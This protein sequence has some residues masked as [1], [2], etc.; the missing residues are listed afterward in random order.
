MHHLSMLPHPSHLLKHLRFPS[1][2]L[3]VLRATP[4][5]LMEI[6]AWSLHWPIQKLHSFSIAFGDK[7]KVLSM[8][9]KILHN[10][11]LFCLSCIFPTSV[12]KLQPASTPYPIKQYKWNTCHHS[13]APK[14]GLTSVLHIGTLAGHCRPP[15]ADLQEPCLRKDQMA[16][17]KKCWDWCQSQELWH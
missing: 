11:I 2:L 6:L 16:L 3:C 4:S 9:Q 14:G 7:A 1:F 13:K 8:V 10:S 15:G 5:Y 12:L 17:G